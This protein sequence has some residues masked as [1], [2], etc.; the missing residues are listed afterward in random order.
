[1]FTGIVDALGRV[2]AVEISGTSGKITV[3]PDEPSFTMDGVAI[4]DSIAVS[5][6]CLTVTAIGGGSFTADV[7]AETLKL[8]T[9]G[10][11]SAGAVVN[12]EKALTLSKPLGGHLVSGHVDGIGTVKAKKV[13]GEN[14]VFDISV[15]GSLAA[16]IVKKGSV[17]V[18]GISL[19]VA[20]LTADGFTMAIVPHTMKATTLSD[21][22]AGDKV[23]VETDMIGKYVQRYLDLEGGG[24]KQGVAP[25]ALTESFL[26]EHG[27]INKK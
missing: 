1:M 14:V 9:L 23:N 19:T 15:D 2:K 12:L 11:L 3:E 26:S 8:T 18:D 27:F 24:K 7:S 17:A 5:G 10:R 21:V 22:S 4:G 13:E 20:A 6:V 16:Q 25:S